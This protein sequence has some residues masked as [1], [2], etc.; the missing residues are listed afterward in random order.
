MF[1]FR[2]EDKCDAKIQ[3][4]TTSQI[5]A[6][7]SGAFPTMVEKDEDEYPH[8]NTD[9]TDEEAQDTGPAFDNDLDSEVVDFTIEEDDCVSMAM[10]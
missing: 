1:H 9:E 5:N 6:C 8:V 2:V 10:V 3:K 4:S 7:R